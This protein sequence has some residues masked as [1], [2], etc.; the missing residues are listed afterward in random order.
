LAALLAVQLLTSCANSEGPQDPPGRSY[1]EAKAQVPLEGNDREPLF[2]R[3]DHFSDPDAAAAAEAVQYYFVVFDILG[4]TSPI[5]EDFFH[6]MSHFATDERLIE[7]RGWFPGPRSPS[8]SGIDY[9]GPRWL[10][11]MNVTELPIHE[12]GVIV[13]TDEGWYGWQPD[14][15]FQEVESFTGTRWSIR[16]YVLRQVEDAGA[17]RWKVHDTKLVSDLLP[18][19]ERAELDA[20]CSDWARH[21]WEGN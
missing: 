9:T 10:W 1:E 19:K 11:I 18:E 14:D 21:D 3:V 6:L 20:A 16:G 5:N 2:W 15:T 4:D 17:A 13:C 8:G 12:L 7:T